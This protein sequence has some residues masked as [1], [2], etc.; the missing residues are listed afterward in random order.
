M[1]KLALVVTAVLSVT[2]CF[3]MPQPAPAPNP[4]EIQAQQKTAFAQSMGY[5]TRKTAQDLEA[6]IQQ[7]TKDFKRTGRKDEARLEAFAPFTIEGVKGTCYTIVMRLGAGATWGPSADYLRFDFRSPSGNGSGGP[8][9]TGP[10][11][12]VSVGCA[13][14]NGPI[15]LTMSP[16]VGQ[17][18]IGT[19]PVELELWSHKLTAEEAEHL[20]ADKQ[21][22]IREQREFAER[23]EAKRQQRANAGC[24]KCDGRYQGCIG[25]G[26]SRSVCRDEYSSCAF[27]EVGADY[28]SACPNPNF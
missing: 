14:A 24:S 21:R 26:R 18:P 20:E 9:V 13:E 7:Q 10:G 11:A 15:A 16:M 28:A 23:E 25:A 19:G 6:V 8:G 1:N 5:P 12:V 4:A 27:R 2:A 3:S 17:D 22:Q